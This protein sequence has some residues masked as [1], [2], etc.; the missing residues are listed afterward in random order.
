MRKYYQIEFFLDC[1]ILGY[2][3]TIYVLIILGGEKWF[4]LWLYTELMKGYTMRIFRGENKDT[5]KNM[6]KCFIGI[7]RFILTI[8][9]F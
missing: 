3:T 9:K 1:E 7:I 6:E 4:S 5:E 2:T 8:W